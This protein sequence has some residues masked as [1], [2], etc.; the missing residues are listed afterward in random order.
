MRPIA[1]LAGLAVLAGAFPAYAD[2]FDYGTPNIQSPLNA[3]RGQMYMRLTHR[4]NGA[5]FPSDSAPAFVMGL[6]LTKNVTVD[7]FTST[8]NHPLD[9]DVGVRYQILDEYDGAPVALTARVG[10]TTHLTGSAIG[11]LTV[12]RNNVLPKLGIGLVGRYFSYVGDYNNPGWMTAAGVGASYELMT[13][14]NLVGDVVA[15]LDQS[16]VAANGFN[17][18]TGLQWWM[19]DTPHVL[20]LFVGRMGPGTTYGRTFS[21]GSDTWR[22]GLEYH[23]HF[24]APFFPRRRIIRTSE[25]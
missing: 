6:G 20:V 17:W 8:R 24:D 3:K 18:S 25:D 22:V 5:E 4:F 11:E 14:L 9:G 16:V 10:Y 7:L 12:S 1:F 2:P 23:A 19:P 21:P 15:P 13:G